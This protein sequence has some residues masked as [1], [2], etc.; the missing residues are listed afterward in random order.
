MFWIKF[1]T[2]WTIDLNFW[3]EAWCAIFCVWLFG[4]LSLFLLLLFVTQC[5]GCCI[6]QS[7]SGVLCDLGIEIIPPGKYFLKFDCWSNKAFRKYE[8][9]IQIISMI[10][11]TKSFLKK[12]TFKNIKNNWCQWILRFEFISWRISKNFWGGFLGWKTWKTMT[13][14]FG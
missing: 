6:L 2:Q 5:F 10:E 12:I 8:D 14:L 4:L 3:D 9:V 13:S 1:W 7:S 11:K